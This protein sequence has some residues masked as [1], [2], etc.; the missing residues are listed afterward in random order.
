LTYPTV[1]TIISVV[2]PMYL[3]SVRHDWPEVAGFTLSRPQ[4]LPYYTFLHFSVAV[5]MRINGEYVDARPGACM[6]YGLNFPQW[7]HSPERLI[8]NWMHPGPEFAELLQQYQIPENTLLY[9]HDTSFISGLF[10]K[11][12]REHYSDN[13]Y[14][15]ELIDGYI[16]EFIIKFHRALYMEAPSV[17]VSNRT[18]AKMRAVR[19]EVLSH[20]EK[21]WTVAE[22][23][24][25][26]SL[27]P[28]R[29]HA[30][31]KTEFA[32]SP[33]QDAIASKI[34]YARSLLVSNEQLTLPEVAEKLGYND[35]YHFIRQFKAVT[36]QPP[37]AYRKE[38]R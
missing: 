35:Q 23:A 19:R 32:T 21:K 34:S 31:Y 7:F 8:H 15:Q 4:G 24:A 5:R 3:R 18:R 2:M 11:I 16:T 12:E 1:F 28:S 26:A 37:G 6:F 33:M 38:M 13:P 27:S 10:Q 36:G 17:V 9:P 20:P 25:L 30:V 29:F 22:M 14:K